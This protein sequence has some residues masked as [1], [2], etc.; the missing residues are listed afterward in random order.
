[1]RMVSLIGAEIYLEVCAD[2]KKSYYHTRAN[3]AH[4]RWQGQ[5]CSC[6]QGKAKLC[7]NQTDPIFYLI[8]YVVR[9][10]DSISCWNPNRTY[11]LAG[12]AGVT[13]SKLSPNLYFMPPRTISRGI[14][15][16]HS[17]QNK[18]SSKPRVTQLGLRQSDSTWLHPAL[19]S[20]VVAE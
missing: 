9:L 15:T 7:P 6:W 5:G 20:R 13:H 10:V 14:P 4:P 2:K 18:A 3:L 16:L 1:M 11:I 12:E 8:L 17:K 19:A